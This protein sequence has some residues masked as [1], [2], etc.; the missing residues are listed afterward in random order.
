MN[1]LRWPA[2][3][4]RRRKPGRDSKR[5]WSKRIE[6]PAKHQLAFN[7]AKAATRGS[8][9]SMVRWPKEGFRFRITTHFKKW[10]CEDR[11]KRG[12]MLCGPAIRWPRA[13]DKCRT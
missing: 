11:Q 4:V 10:I 7:W 6:E 5:S 13:P 9:N 1:L 2:H 12:T 3:S 8:R